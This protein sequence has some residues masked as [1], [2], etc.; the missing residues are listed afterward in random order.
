MTSS[1]FTYST[2]ALWWIRGEPRNFCPLVA[3]RVTELLIESKPTQRH[4]VHTNLNIGDIAT[5][6][7]GPEFLKCDKSE[8]PIDDVP[9]PTPPTDEAELKS[10]F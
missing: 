7:K 3:N 9:I 1:F 2:T 8:W 4:Y 6:I 5:S 10:L